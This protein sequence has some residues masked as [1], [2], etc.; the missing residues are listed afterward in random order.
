[1]ALE[2]AHEKAKSKDG[3]TLVIDG[4]AVS[5]V[6]AILRSGQWARTRSSRRISW[7]LVWKVP[8]T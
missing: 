7:R 1:L 3:E 2:I 8:D 5:I 6:E 4:H